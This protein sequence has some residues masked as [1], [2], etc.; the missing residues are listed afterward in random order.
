MNLIMNVFGYPFGW[1]MWAMYKLVSSYGVALLLFSLVVK[2]ILFPLALKQQKSSI[3][4]QLMQPR[5]QEIQAKYKNNPSKMNEELGNL[6]AKEDYSPYAGCLP[7]LIQL[8]VV[9]GLLDVVYRPLTHLL[10]FSGDTVAALTEI[11]KTLGVTLKGYTPQISL[12]KSVMSN[13]AA[14]SAVGADAVARMQGLDMNFLGMD[15]GSVPNLPWKGGWNLLILI[16]ILS[17]LTALMTSVITMRANPTQQSAGGGM[18]AMMYLMPVMSLYI[19]FL[20]P[21]GVGIYWTL[22]NL[23]SC[24][25]TLILNKIHNPKEVAEK[26]KQAEEERARRERM[27]RIEAKK[28][29]KEARKQG[30]EREDAEYLSNKEKVRAA[31]RRYAERYGDAY[32]DD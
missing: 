6:Y 32:E 2:L 15:L 30:K 28:R 13:P 9:F 17:G 26:L 29:A 11:G 21:A 18:K 5:I 10:R 14:Y 7:L 3:K 22:S 12:Y 4:M 1:L 8:P 23:F 25:Q 27:E 24:I 16:P 19:T 20:V 31:R